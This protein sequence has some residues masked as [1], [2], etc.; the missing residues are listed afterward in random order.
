MEKILAKI[1]EKIVSQMSD[2][3]RNEIKAA[4]VKLE[5]VAAE[6]GNPWD[7]IL[8]LILKVVVGVE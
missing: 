6:T 2:G 7:D 1:A 8:V 5:A 3:L 4:V